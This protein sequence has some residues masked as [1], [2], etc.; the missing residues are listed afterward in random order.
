MPTQRLNIT[1]HG[2]IS[3]ILKTKKN[4]SEFLEESVRKKDVNDRK[5]EVKKKAA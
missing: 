5:R 1:L 2:E 3:E 4:K